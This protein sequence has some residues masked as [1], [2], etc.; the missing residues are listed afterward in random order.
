VHETSDAFV[1]TAEVPGVL[2][3]DIRVHAVDN[4]VTI[5]GFRR[6]RL[7]AVRTVPSARTRPG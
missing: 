6:E 4:A 3:P 7:A 5:S 2:E 1:L